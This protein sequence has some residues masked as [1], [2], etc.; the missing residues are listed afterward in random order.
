MI[1]LAFDACDPADDLID[2]NFLLANAVIAGRT[3][4]RA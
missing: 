1:A 3:A 2:V 4:P